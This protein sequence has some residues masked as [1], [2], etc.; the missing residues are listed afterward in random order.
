MPAIYE[1]Q[2]TS[3]GGSFASDQAALTIGGE[4]T[5]PLGIVQ[6]VQLSFAQ[7]IARIYDVSN[8]GL[9]NAAGVAG[10]GTVPVFYVGG[11]TQGQATI[12][13]VV[14]P[15]SGALCKFYQ[16]M[17]SVC[18]PQDL[19]F[20]FEGGCPPTANPGNIPGVT[21]TDAVSLGNQAQGFG[22]RKNGVKYSVQAAV[23]TNLG[24]SVGAQD[25]IVNENISLMF[26][27]LECD[28]AVNQ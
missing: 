13:R 11:R 24:I 15:Q 7:Q 5:T 4:S 14:G 12:A 3:F 28:E 16:L 6:N 1:R 17:G 10:A 21:G 19:T 20:T 22:P 18:D 2:K 8:G 25:M 27:N 23:M 26:A 9:S